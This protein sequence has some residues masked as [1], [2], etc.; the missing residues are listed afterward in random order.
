MNDKLLAWACK[1]PLS[2]AN[3]VGSFQFFSHSN[4]KR[5][6]GYLRIYLFI[7]SSMR[8]VLTSGKLVPYIMA[9]IVLSLIYT[10]LSLI[11]ILHKCIMYYWR[12]NNSIS[13]RY[14]DQYSRQITNP[15]QSF[16]IPFNAVWRVYDYYWGRKGYGDADSGARFLR[17]SSRPFLTD[18]TNDLGER[19]AGKC[20]SVFVYMYSLPVT[21]SSAIRQYMSCL[22]HDPIYLCDRLH[23]F[24]RLCHDGS[25]KGNYATVVVE[26]VLSRLPGSMGCHD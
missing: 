11:Y 23:S 6:F 20:F 10:Q 12:N 14:E 9:A 26:G 15:Y 2:A 18:E 3:L 13:Q 19:R 17:R 22:C 4:G 1:L 25:W 8:T 21:I 5:F 24:A 7:C 16:A